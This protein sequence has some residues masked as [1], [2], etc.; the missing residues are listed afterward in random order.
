MNQLKLGIWEKR[1]D[2]AQDALEHLFWN[3]SIGMYNI[4]TPCPNGEC[5]TIFHYWWMAHAV[6]VLVDGLQRTGDKRYADRLGALHHGLLYRNGGA[7]PNELYDDMEWMALAWLRA[8][9][10]TGQDVY[11]ETAL[12]LWQDIQTGWN[13]HMGGG[14]AWQKSQPDY[15][16][17]PANAPAAILAARLYQA[18]GDARD[19]EWAHLIYNWQKNHLVDPETGFVWDGMNRTGDGSIDKEWKFTYCQGV[20]IGA[21][22]EL[23]RI[24]NEQ[25]YLQDARRTFAS[26]IRELVSAEQGALQD[27]GNGDGGLFKGILIRYTAEY[28]KADPDAADAAAFL[29][30][31]A[32]LLWEKGKSAD[33]ALFG[34]DWTS[35]ASGVITLSSQL[36]GI[37]LLEMMAGMTRKQ[38]MTG[39]LDTADKESWQE[40]AGRLQ[41]SLQRHYYNEETGIMNQWYPRGRNRADDNFYYW[42]QAHVIDVLADGYE[43]TG[44]ADYARRIQDLSRSLRAYNGGSFLHHY[45]DDMEWMALALLRAY[46]ISGSREYMSSVMELWTDIKTAWNSHCG[47]GMAWKKDQTDYKNTP[48]NAP[49]AI[50]AAR[51]Y[52]MLHEE[53]Y[54]EWAKRIYDWNKENLVDPATGFVWDGMNRRGDGQID[55]DWEFTYCQGIFLGAGLELYRSTGDRAYAIDAKRT[56]EACLNR[57]CDPDTMMLPDEGIDDTGLFKGILIRYLVQL[58]QQFPENARIQEV[59]LVNAGRLWDEGLD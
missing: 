40:H 57:L 12:I 35:A 4:E 2:Q 28:A 16:N 54:L 48:A 21:A 7:W 22:V 25:V 44:D 30:M 11:K 52:G 29:S 31:N 49:A 36:S 18:F 56:A 15:K 26:A 46:K 53:E 20:Y 23:Y 32:G 34:T 59:I 42:W 5:N 13:G 24:T 55:Y 14:I 50:L 17:T 58:Y 19:L 51:L 37:M 33:E 39:K 8:Y 6:D 45:Y 27:E 9:Q 10:A 1:A 43:R 3:E 41:Q 38:A 47:G